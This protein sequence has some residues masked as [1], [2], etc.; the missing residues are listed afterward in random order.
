MKRNNLMGAAVL[1]L[2]CLGAGAA[3]ADDT[4]NTAPNWIKTVADQKLEAVDGSSVTVSPTPNGMSL[5]VTS[6]TGDTR[7]NVYVLM[8]DKLGTVSDGADG[9]HLV[10]VFRATDNGFAAQFAD[11]HSETLALNAAGGLSLTLASAQNGQVCM[12]WYPQG[13]SFSEAERRAAVAEY[14]QRLGLS[15]VKAPPHAHSCDIPPPA[16]TKTAAL[17]AHQP[18]PQRGA[19]NS[20]VL[21]PVIVR[22][23]VVHAID[24]PRASPVAVAAIPAPVTTPHLPTVSMS[25]MII[26][27]S[28]QSPAQTASADAVEP[29]HGASGCLSVDTNGSDL[30]F[31][32]QCGFSV[33]FSYCLQKADDPSL[34]CDTGSRAG[35]VAANGFVPLL[36]GTNIKS[37]D[38]EHEF[39]WVGCTGAAGTVVAHLDHSDPPA[40]RCVRT[41]A[42]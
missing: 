36:P 16:T 4:P 28:A 38:A 32:N 1:G 29:G 5:S 34:V 20:A 18:H 24:A 19:A 37:A 22:T 40:G 33:T 3:L 23:S 2:T 10:G 17:P 39:R 15:D 35:D 9:S 8:S 11:G 42:S 14:A 41:T 21:V 31:Q 25:S 30:G 6:P 26:P 13:H 27:V 7:K 12:A